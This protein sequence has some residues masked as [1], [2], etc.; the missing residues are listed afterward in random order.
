MILE[1]QLYMNQL[2]TFNY[3]Y[4]TQGNLIEDVVVRQS[5]LYPNYHYFEYDSKGR[6]IKDSN[7]SDR[8]TEI[9]FWKYNDNGLIIEEKFLDTNW[10]S[11]TYNEV[12][13]NGDWIVVKRVDNSKTPQT[14]ESYIKTFEYNQRGLLIR[15]YTIDIDGTPS[16]ELI[17]TYDKNDFLI[18]KK[19]YNIK[20]GK[21]FNIAYE[22]KFD[23][24][25]N[26]VKKVTMVNDLIEREE[27]RKIKYF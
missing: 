1:Y 8:K 20:E 19:S 11:A 15:E 18:E 4:D 3:L 25:G 23:K 14:N 26:W 9:K 13:E 21:T 6:I 7:I 5:D 2:S 12:D 16:W 24:V 27:K 10:T 22:Y 17:N